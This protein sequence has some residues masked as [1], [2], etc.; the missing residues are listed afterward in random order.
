MEI[1]ISFLE[2]WFWIGAELLAFL[3]IMG[4]LAYLVWEGTMGWKNDND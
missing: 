2:E 4:T 1:I 3:L